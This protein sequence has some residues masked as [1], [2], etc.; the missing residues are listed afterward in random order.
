MFAQL[1]ASAL[2]GLLL[3]EVS[4]TRLHKASCISAFKSLFR[5]VLMVVF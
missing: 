5:M 3:Y 4:L 1:R 2:A